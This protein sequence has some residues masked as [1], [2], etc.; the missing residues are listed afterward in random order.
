MVTFETAVSIL[1]NAQELA[2]K[3]KSRK[4]NEVL[5]NLQDELINLK[6]QYIESDEKY[7]EIR[8]YIEVPEDIYLDNHGFICRKNDNRKYCPKCWNENRK[9][10]LMP[11]F[12]IKVGKIQSNCSACGHAIYFY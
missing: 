10:S 6:T 1:K 9:L 11:N 2:K 5:L 7:K 3:I 8:K 12:D 4:L